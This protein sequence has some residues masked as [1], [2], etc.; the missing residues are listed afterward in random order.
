MRDREYI[1]RFQQWDFEAF[2]ALYDKYIDQIFAFVY[3]KTSDRQ[4]AEDICSNVWMKALKSLEFFG[5]DDNA[6]FKAWIYC[7]ANNTIIDY[8][9]TRK[10]TV[11]AQEIELCGISDDFAAHIDAKNKL[12]SVM[13]YIN[14]LK[15]VEKEI[16]VLRI[17]DDLSYKEIAKIIGKTEGTC[18]KVFSRSLA[19]IKANISLLLLCILIG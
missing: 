19:K 8:Y 10:E 9:R 15:P 7:I 1:D 16:C 11:D 12:K 18:K 2:G 14:E 4:V 3:R 13:K 6:Y 17:W 5:N